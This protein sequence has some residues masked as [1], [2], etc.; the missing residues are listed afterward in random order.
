MCICF[1]LCAK[2]SA[3]LS[4]PSITTV[5]IVLVSIQQMVSIHWIS[6][7]PCRVQIC[8]CS[9]YILAPKFYFPPVGSSGKSCPGLTP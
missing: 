1:H 2:L 4:K 7:T 3:Y 9:F 6:L 5:A 8:L